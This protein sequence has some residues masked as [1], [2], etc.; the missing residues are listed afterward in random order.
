MAFN[1]YSRAGWE[2]L[3][4]TYDAFRARLPNQ[5]EQPYVPLVRVPK[6]PI[7]ELT[8]KITKK[9]KHIEYI[10]KKIDGCVRSK[11]AG[12]SAYRDAHLKDLAAY[13]GRL[14]KLTT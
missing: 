10:S 11:R 3:M 2:N 7:E 13:R 1:V 4:S 12:L 9:E 5:V 8:I 14:A 6:D